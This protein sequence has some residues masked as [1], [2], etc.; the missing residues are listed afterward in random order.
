M[1]QMKTVIMPL[2]IELNMAYAA[3]DFYQLLSLSLQLPSKPLVQALYDRSYW[4]DTVSILEDLSFSKDDI[5]QE[6][7]NIHQ[8]RMNG[9]ANLYKELRREYTRLFYDLPKPR[10]AIYESLF[11]NHLTE[12][13]DGMMLFLNPIVQDVEASY[14]KAGLKVHNSFREPADHMATELEFMMS[15]YANKGKAMQ[16]E[17]QKELEVINHHIVAFQQNHFNKWA[18]EFFNSMEE[19]TT[20]EQ[21]RIIARV[22]KKGLNHLNELELS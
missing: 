10:I 7:K 20:L 9:P 21:Y 4:D 2:E 8:L 3:S 19:Q 13:K 15:L 14:K 17:N 11:L 16:S 18:I 22:A 12:E 5:L 6:M 1:E